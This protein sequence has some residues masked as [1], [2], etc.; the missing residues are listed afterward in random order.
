M[1][2]LKQ[3]MGFSSNFRIRKSH[4]ENL[5][6]IIRPQKDRKELSEVIWLWFEKN[7][8]VEEQ[9]ILGRDIFEE[10]KEKNK[11]IIECFISL[12]FGIKEMNFI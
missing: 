12:I 1:L 9:F 2:F 5:M 10:W 6:R 3:F 11:F 7:K 8:L 4:F